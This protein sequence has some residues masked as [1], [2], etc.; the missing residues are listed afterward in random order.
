MVIREERVMSEDIARQIL[1]GCEGTICLLLCASGGVHS[2]ITERN[3]KEDRENLNAIGIFSKKVDVEVI[4][5]SS[6]LA[7]HICRESNVEYGMRKRAFEKDLET[8]HNKGEIGR[9]SILRPGRIKEKNLFGT[10]YSRITRYIEREIRQGK[11]SKRKQVAYGGLDA[12]AM[13]ILKKDL[14]RLFREGARIIW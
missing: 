13:I 7:L 12:V 2:P 3:I 9:L 8:I 11:N 5:I 14:K 4:M 6:I 10:T 1:E